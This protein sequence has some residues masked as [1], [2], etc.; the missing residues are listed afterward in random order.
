MA[1]PAARAKMW[2]TFASAVSGGS[3]RSVPV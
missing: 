3:G 1:A 2:E